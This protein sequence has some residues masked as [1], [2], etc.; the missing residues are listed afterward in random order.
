VT[1]E[2]TPN[3]KALVVCACSDAN[4]G[5]GRPRPK[6]WKSGMHTRECTCRECMAGG[7]GKAERKRVRRFGKKSGLTPTPGSGRHRGYDLSGVLAVEETSARV[8]V[9][10]LERYLARKDV[11]EKMARVRADR[12]RPGALLLSSDDKPLI[13]LIDPDALAAL[14]IAASGS[15]MEAAQS[16][17]DALG[18]VGLPVFVAA[19]GSADTTTGDSTGGAA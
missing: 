14:C 12:Q 9:E 8:L 15:D 6:A 19:R 1:V 10:P 11:G 7:Y 16:L 18:G 4:C 2:V 13:A 5:E 17:I 3:F